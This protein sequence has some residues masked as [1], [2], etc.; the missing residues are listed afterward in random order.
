MCAVIHKFVVSKMVSAGKL[1]QSASGLVPEYFCTC[2]R[3]SLSYQ[4]H[5]KG[6]LWL[7][8]LIY[9]NL[10]HFSKCL[11]FLMT[12]D[13]RD[14]TQTWCFVCFWG[15]T[16]CLCTVMGKPWQA[17]LHQLEEG[18]LVL[19]GCTSSTS[20]T[21]PGWGNM[22]K[23]SSFSPWCYHSSSPKWSPALIHTGKKGDK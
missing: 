16:P 23:I 15:A 8:L 21:F 6:W 9:F 1:Y 4:K 17:E 7:K 14:R 18:T 22:G 3:K 20:G 13:K 19:P 10:D 11:C 12:K 5:Q 2:L